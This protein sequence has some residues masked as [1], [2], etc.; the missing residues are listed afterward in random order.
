MKNSKKTAGALL[1]DVLKS[2]N[3]KR[4]F[5]VPGES[6][7]AVLDALFDSDIDFVNAR[8]EGGA[9]FMAE[10][11]GKLTGQPGIAFVTRGPGATHA[12]IGVHAAMQNSSPLILFVGQIA[13]D[14][15][16]RE[17]FQEIDCRAF[18]GSIAKWVTEIDDATRLQELVLRAFHIAISGRP[19]PV[20]I[21]LPEDMLVE[22]VEAMLLSPVSISEA[23]PPDEAVKALQKRLSAAKRPLLIAGGGGWSDQGR[24]DLNRFSTQ[25]NLPVITAFRSQ[26]LIDNNSENFVGDAGLGKPE[27]LSKALL[28]SDLTLAVNIRF[29]EIFTDGWSW[30]KPPKYPTP[31]IHSHN[32]AAQL[33]KIYQADLSLHAGPNTLLKCLAEFKACDASPWRDDLRSAFLQSRKP[34]KAK[35]SVNV[36]ALCTRLN[37]LAERDAIVTNGAGNFA[38]YPGR[39]IRFGTRRLIAP[40][41]GAMAAGLPA[42]IAAKLEHPKRQVICFAGDGDFQMS[43][44]EL[45]AVMQEQLGLIIFVHNNGSYGTIRM[46]Q[47]RDY[48]K[49]VSGTELLNPDFKAIASAYNC[50]YARLEKTEE[51]DSIFAQATQERRTTIIEMMT[52]PDDIAPGKIL[53]QNA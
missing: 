30:A 23:S 52:D 31:L 25:N 8:H 6:Y 29:G 24:A 20:V 48:P 14:M 42:A 1:V 18:F 47:E 28:E 10:A 38:I 36:A 27:Y 2:Q 46:H 16:E 4:V 35:G 33:G 32:D 21:A 5:G 41:V 19:G 22:T 9:S 53:N 26:D 50:A 13:R 43:L 40:Q 39:Y 34:L 7:L 44:Q 11:H 15:R 3:V 45:G 17:A 49:R 37:D 12:S 51:F